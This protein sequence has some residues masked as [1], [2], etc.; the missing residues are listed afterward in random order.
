MSRYVKLFGFLLM[1]L[2]CMATYCD[3]QPNYKVSSYSKLNN[4]VSSI[5]RIVRDGNGLMWFATND[6]LYRYD[7]YEFKN[8]KSHSGDGSTCHRTISITCIPVVRGSSG[9]W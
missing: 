6:G 4:S 8:F 3:A 2:S 1:L 9:V 7:G 5:R